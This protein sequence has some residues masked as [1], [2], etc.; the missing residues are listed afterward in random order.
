MSKLDDLYPS[1]SQNLKA[2]DLQGHEVKV[3]IESNE[4]AEFDN[5]NRLVLKFKGKEKGLVL[6]KTNAMKIADAYGD[7]PDNWAGKEI[8]IYPDKTD[9]QGKMVDCLRVRIP[10]SLED[11]PF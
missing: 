2:E 7:D 5:G 4:V 11:A 9:Y 8:I 3:S 10:A 6:N 1:K